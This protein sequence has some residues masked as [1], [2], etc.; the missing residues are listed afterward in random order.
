M[1]QGSVSIESP[2][3]EKSMTLPWHRGGLKWK[4]TAS[5][6]GLI[7]LLGILVIGIVYYFTGNAV[8]KQV[9]L[10]STAIATN[11]SDASAGYVS[12][13]SILE[14]D[15]LIA[16][17]GRLDG[18]AYAYIQDPKGEIL[19]TSLQ[20]F[21]VELKESTGTGKQQASISRVTQVRGKAVYETRVPL[22]DGQL[23][24]VHVGL[25]AD[26][27]RQDVR[28]AVLPIV[29]FI[30]ICLVVGIAISVILASRTIRPILELKS[31]ADD[32]SRGRLDASVSMQSNDEIGELARSLERMRASLKAAMLRLS[33]DF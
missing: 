19:A 6:S 28:A 5:F 17:Y 2:T 22:L 3:L 29:G 25:W 16:K 31:I 20:P 8:Q 14:L 21:P 30:A 26:T 24:A 10:R 23:G 15:A 27:V 11:L 7:L 33:K 32:I 1:V 12:K 13:K 9:D 4:I 18:V